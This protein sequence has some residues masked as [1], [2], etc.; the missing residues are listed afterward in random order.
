MTGKLPQFVLK[1][2]DGDPFLASF[3]HGK[4]SI[5]TTIYTTCK[6]TSDAQSKA[7]AD[8]QRTHAKHPQW[9]DVGLV[10]ITVDPATDTA[11]VLSE[12]GRA[13]RC[14]PGALAIPYR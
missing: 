3:M 9:D 11:E 4:V 10:S 2:Q 8:L 6:G 12:Y 5:V 13:L 7:F 1:D 14:R